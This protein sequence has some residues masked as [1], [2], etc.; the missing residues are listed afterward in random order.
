MIHTERVSTGVVALDPLLEGGF[1]KGRSILITGEPGTGKTIFALQFLRAGLEQGENGVLVTADENPLDLV[2]Q[3]ASL[4]WNFETY[5][6]NRQ[7]AILN[8]TGLFSAATDAESII[9]LSKAVGE[10]AEFAK[11]FGAQRLALDP[12]SPFLCQRDSVARVQA[13]TR[14]LI[15]QLRAALATTNLL[16]SYSV[17]H[18]GERSINGI[19]EYLVAGAIVLEM[20][21]QNGEFTRALVVEKMRATNVKPRQLEFDIVKGEGITL[22]RCAKVSQL[23]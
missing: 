11:Q 7:L 10:L 8:A 5:L 4:G 15:Q 2:E 17:P 21:W 3:A 16:T 19:E 13:R 9:D 20:I 18:S 23:G 12:A 1:P 14:S 6:Q 22:S